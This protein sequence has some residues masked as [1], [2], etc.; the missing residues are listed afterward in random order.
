MNPIPHTWLSAQDFSGAALPCW[1]IYM[2]KSQLREG[3][4][5]KSPYMIPAGPLSHWET[6]VVM[7]S[8]VKKKSQGAGG[9][10]GL[11]FEE[12]VGWEMKREVLEKIHTERN[13]KR[14]DGGRGNEIRGVK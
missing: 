13:Q 8:N 5:E 1:L 7:N 3:F 9:W 2:F 11:G 4:W 10:E 6:N 12:D 14:Q